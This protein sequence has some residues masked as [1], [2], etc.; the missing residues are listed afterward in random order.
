MRPINL[1]IEGFNS[2][3][4]RV[5]VDFSNLDLFAITGPTGA[6]KTSIIDSITYALYGC[7]PRIGEKQVSELISQGLNRVSVL[8]QFS[9]G[10]SEYRIARVGKWT[11]KQIN[12]E[13]R[14]EQR[15]GDEWNSLA[16]SVNQMKPMIEQII[17]LDF[18]GFTKSVVLP[19]GR[20][21]EFLKGKA[22]DRRKILSDLLDLSVY[23]RM[24]RR[25]NEMHTQFKAKATALD[26]VLKKEYVDATAEQVAKLRQL[27]EDTTPQL[28]AIEL[29]LKVVSSFLPVAHEL[30]QAHAKLSKT[31]EEL[32]A[33]G[34]K[35]KI[36]ENDLQRV[37]KRIE[38]FDQ[39]LT[40]VRDSLKRNKHD[41]ARLVRLSRLLEKAQGLESVLVEV[42]ETEKLRKER[43]AKVTKVDAQIKR[44]ERTAHDAALACVVGQQELEKHRKLLRGLQKKYGSPDAIQSAIDSQ[45]Q[46]SKL[47]KAHAKL[48][49]ELKAKEDERKSLKQALATAES[50]ATL[51]RERRDGLQTEFEA[52]TCS[53]SAESLKPGLSVGEACPVCEQTVERLP[54]SRKHQPLDK[55]R[56]ELAGAAQLA[57][58]AETRAANLRGQVQ[59][60]QREAASLRSRIADSAES[61]QEIAERL[62]VFAGADLLTLKTEC[63]MAQRHAD[64]CASRLEDLKGKSA[65]ESSALKDHQRDRTLLENEIDGYTRQQTKLGKEISRL[66]DELGEF[67][68]AKKLQA[69]VAEEEKERTNREELTA[70]RDA[71]SEQLSKAKDDVATAMA[72]VEGLETMRQSVEKTIAGLKERIGEHAGALKT[73]FPELKNASGER[74][75]ASQLEKRSSDLQSRRDNARKDVIDLQSQINTTETKLVRAAEMRRELEDHRTKMAISKTLGNSLQGDEFIDF[76]QKEA[77]ARLAADGSIHLKTLS[78]DRYSLSVDKDEFQVVDHW[79]ADEP[80]AITTLSGGESFLA[81]L[82]LALAL[83]EGLSGLSSGH[84]KFALESL[85]LD[86]GFG[87][88]DPET[89]E[90]VVAG[91]EGLS[92]HERLIG[93]VSHVGQVADRMPVRINVVKSIR[94]STIDIAN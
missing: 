19:Q 92:T 48:E 45:K 28:K 87:G 50:D 12:T 17:G 10:K 56:R 79:N 1:Q 3:R 35:R 14:L 49:S 6:G 84:T 4:E 75:E 38:D 81:S 78:A 43:S 30:R 63:E 58:A 71:L 74:D 91:I 47:E 59:P 64:D 44:L 85:F 73:Q 31:E 25:A 2:F 60:L 51:S 72:H 23:G 27:L 7:T 41:S 53:H 66:R 20:F 82:A 88:L 86:E 29:K 22:D 13:V 94:G 69:E 11:G 9:S 76:I 24:M 62:S 46:L 68:N 52:L 37:R 40:A 36:A 54:K 34:P 65:D 32:K 77:Y 18:N 8:F 39:K 5:F 70:S 93:I 55:A 16:S 42:E 67:V 90:L 26:D 83:A 80:R 89:L 33:I 15:L 57:S 21:D 61:I